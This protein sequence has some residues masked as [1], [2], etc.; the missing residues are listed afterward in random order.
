[1]QLRTIFRSQNLHEHVEALQDLCPR[2]G[3]AQIPETL[4]FNTG[5]F[6]EGC[7]GIVTMKG[8]PGFISQYLF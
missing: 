8:G 7:C 5:C 1:M 2:P 3:P 4:I 6:S